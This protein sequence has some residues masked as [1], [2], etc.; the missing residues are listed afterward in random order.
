MGGRLCA[1]VIMIAVARRTAW[2][3]PLLLTSALCHRI[4]IETPPDPR[5]T[6]RRTISEPTLD[7]ELG[8]L[9]ADEAVA[10]LVLPSIPANLVGGGFA[11]KP[12]SV[13]QL[14]SI[15]KE[16]VYMDTMTK[17]EPDTDS[18]RVVGL[19]DDEDMQ[20]AARVAAEAVLQQLIVADFDTMERKASERTVGVFLRMVAAKL[21][22]GHSQLHFLR[23]VQGKKLFRADRFLRCFL[24]RLAEAD[25]E[26]R[27]GHDPGAMVPA[28]MTRDKKKHYTQKQLQALLTQASVY[29]RCCEWDKPSARTLWLGTRRQCVEGTN[30]WKFRFVH[31]HNGGRWVCYRDQV[32]VEDRCTTPPDGGPAVQQLFNFARALA[33]L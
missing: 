6:M 33:L 9:L 20:D 10:E 16:D 11:P 13:R 8:E 5:R 28:A 24:A 12:D 31:F 32:C 25:I 26:G 30:T 7:K 17:V 23:R 1:I 22:L 14:Y 27:P 3:A 21:G 15:Y 2:S 19:C 18:V 4:A 29:A